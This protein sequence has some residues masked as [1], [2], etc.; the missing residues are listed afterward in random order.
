MLEW[1]FDRIPEGE[2]ID[3]YRLIKVGD[4]VVGGILPVAVVNDPDG[5]A[6]SII[7]FSGEPDAVEGGVA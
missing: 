6:F 7:T 3:G 5:N 2:G 4:R 1:T